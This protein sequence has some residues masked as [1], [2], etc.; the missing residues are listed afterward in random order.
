MD[1][2]NLTFFNLKRDK[3]NAVVTLLHKSVSDI[4]KAMV[5]YEQIDGKRKSIRCNGEGC[6]LC[7]SG[8][9]AEP[10]IFIHL[11]NHN[12][13]EEQV[14]SRT[15]KIIPQLSEVESSWGDLCDAVLSI[16][17]EGD[18]FPKYTVTVLNPKQYE[19]VNKELVGKNVAYR[20]FMTR[21]NDELSQFLNT[22][23]MPK[24]EKK[25]YLSKEEYAKKKAA[26]SSKENKPSE[27]ENEKA[28]FEQYSA[29]SID[30]LP[31]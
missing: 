10:R 8:S 30:D 27:F 3:Q 2:T 14:W 15:D 6:P 23:V 1:S 28:K 18:S 29:T 22:G 21:S 5:H 4:E 26:E 7:N 16:T 9:K 17:R 12:T 19:A 13:K 11:Y 24:H 31:F 20:C 25:E